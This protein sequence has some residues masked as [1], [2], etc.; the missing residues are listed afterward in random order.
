MGCSLFMTGQ[1]M[2]DLRIL[3]HGIIGWEDCPSGISEDE[4]DSFTE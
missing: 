3:C 2:V 1:H 4:I